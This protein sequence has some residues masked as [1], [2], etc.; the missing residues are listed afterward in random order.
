MPV[1]VTGGNQGLHIKAGR[2]TLF[3]DQCNQAQ[4]GLDI[5]HSPSKHTV[6][7]SNRNALITGIMPTVNRAPEV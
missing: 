1:T 5:T 2:T 3:A 6:L 7:S 4:I